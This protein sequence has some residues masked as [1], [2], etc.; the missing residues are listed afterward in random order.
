LE[1]KSLE[2]AS[3]WGAVVKVW[4]VIVAVGGGL[5]CEVGFGETFGFDRDG[6]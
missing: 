2:A 4:V 3:G 5:L 6:G 1:E